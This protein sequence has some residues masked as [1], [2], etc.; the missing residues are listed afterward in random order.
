MN[1]REFPLPILGGDGA[2]ATICKLIPF[3]SLIAQTEDLLFWPSHSHSFLL[4][5]GL[6]QCKPCSVVCIAGNL[7]EFP[8]PILCTSATIVPG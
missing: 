8:L 5:C 7:R 6:H 2:G 1:L 3:C 4:I